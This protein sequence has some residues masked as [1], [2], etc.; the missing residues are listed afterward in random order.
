MQYLR[1]GNI[2]WR[3]IGENTKD[4]M[5]F[6]DLEKAYDRVPR[7]EVWICMRE[8]GMPEKCVRIVQEIYE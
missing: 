1:C 2:I 7:Q 4:C 5:L 3:N 8:N 6:I